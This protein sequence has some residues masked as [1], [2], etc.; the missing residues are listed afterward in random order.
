MVIT[1]LSDFGD[2]Y[3]ASMKGVILG[4]APEASI[5]DISHSVPR[6]DVRA[7]AFMLMTCARYFPS[8]TVHV[9]VVDPGVGTERCPIAVMAKSV[10]SGT[11]YFIGPDNGLL[12][13]AARS[14]GELKVYELTNTNLFL[15]SVSSTFHGRDVFAPVG[16]HISRGLKISDVGRQIF[17]FVNLDFGEGTK[18][19]GSLHGNI[20][21]IDSFGNIITNIPSKIAGFKS[22]DV[23]EIQ[24]KR[25]LFQKSYGFCKAGEP[26][27]LIGSHGYLEIAVNQG[28]AA[29]YF[30]K[31]QGD[32]IILKI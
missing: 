22:G 18:K 10:D 12:I 3:P 5:V 23:L 8:G 19:D 6:Q 31:K 21:F 27:A 29:A 30:N 16:A 9:A 28:S 14:I 17:D 2:V 32:N 26:L 4:I 13:P 7:G 24:K 15:S 1:L 20:I 25:V 11:H